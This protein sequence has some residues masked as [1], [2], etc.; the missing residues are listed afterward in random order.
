MDINKGFKQMK[1]GLNHTFA[2]NKKASPIDE[3]FL[4]LI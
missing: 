1:S 4:N 3:A 2:K